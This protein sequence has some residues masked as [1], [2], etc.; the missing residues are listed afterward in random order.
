[1]FQQP[2]QGGDKIPF[3]ELIGALALFIVRDH[4]TGIVTTFGEKDAVGADVHILDGPKAGTVYDNSLIFQGALIGALKSAIGGDPVLAR[5][6]QGTP[7]PGQNA[8]FILAPFTQADVPLATACWQRIQAQ[9]FQPPAQQQAAPA[10]PQP[11]PA[12]AAPYQAAAVPAAASPAPAPAAPSPAAGTPAPAVN[13]EAL[14]PEVQELLRQAGQ[15]P[16]A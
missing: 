11:A 6:G 3:A 16:A 5:I 8:P 9:Q 7:K 4:R 14:P 12:A 1:M 13:W 2:A 15:M 10:A